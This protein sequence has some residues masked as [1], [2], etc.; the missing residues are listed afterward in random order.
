LPVKAPVRTDEAACVVSRVTPGRLAY[1]RW[2]RLRA[3]SRPHTWRPNG[4]GR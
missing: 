2:S 4:R 1:A 3:F